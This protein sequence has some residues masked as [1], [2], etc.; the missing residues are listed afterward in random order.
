RFYREALALAGDSDK[1]TRFAALLGVARSA[2]WLE[3]Y[4][5]AEASYREALPLAANNEDQA[6]ATAGLARM[7]N[8]GDRPR[9]AFEVSSPFVSTS[10]DNALEAGRAALSLGW[11]EKAA[12]LELPGI[13]IP[14]DIEKSRQGRDLAR[15]RDELYVRTR[16]S[17]NFAFEYG[18][19]SDDVRTYDS[20]V[21]IAFSSDSLGQFG[22]QPR[23]NVTT[24]HEVFDEQAARAEIS[25][26]Q[27]G[28]RI[29]LS[30]DLKASTNL[31]VAR[32]NSWTYG[33][34]QAEISYRR[35]DNW[36]LAFS[37]DRDAVKT[38]TALTNRIT[39]RTETIG[40]D[41]RLGDA[42]LAGALLRQTFSDG[43]DRDG[44]VLRI[45]SPAFNIGA[46][47]PSLAVQLYGRYFENSRQDVI[48]YFNPRR[49]EEQRFNFIF[50]ARLSPDWRLRAI[51]G[52][53]RQSVESEKS[54]TGTAEVKLIGHV[55]R[56]AHVEITALYGDT[57]AFASS[58]AGYKR[59]LIN[60]SFVVPW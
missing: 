43:N 19:D 40:G 5:L 1:E 10:I 3:D 28:V 51:L 46:G 33:V 35:S 56:K 24:R 49:F 14:P 52:P 60:A 9:A 29:N 12:V 2:A 27:S 15:L 16:P 17:V 55:D 41:V 4:K 53:G 42:V 34:W 6:V 21:G 36:G 7:L 20:T 25:R 44:G 13:T 18:K 57:A 31:G 48:G 58:G 22:H 47:G 26:L 32:V 30:D 38:T 59:S 37:A 54:N 8:I 45:T 50:S 39:V 11:E 23:W